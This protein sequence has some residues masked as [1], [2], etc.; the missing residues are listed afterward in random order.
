MS[1]KSPLQ[2]NIIDCIEK[3]GIYCNIKQHKAT[4]KKH[5]EEEKQ[6]LHIVFPSRHD[7]FHLGFSFM[8]IK[9]GNRNEWRN[10]IRKCEIRIRIRRKTTTECLIIA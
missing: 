5:K 10:E 6:F 8:K 4:Y 3:R 9:T 1:Y 2:F 7:H